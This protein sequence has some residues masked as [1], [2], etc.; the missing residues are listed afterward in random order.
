[1]SSSYAD[2]KTH[3]VRLSPELRCPRNSIG[4]DSGGLPEFFYFRTYKL[5]LEFALGFIMIII[6]FV[7]REK[8]ASNDIVL[9][10]DSW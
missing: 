10:P 6:R 8:M 3:V 1:M 5:P 4:T 9:T 2:I 7:F